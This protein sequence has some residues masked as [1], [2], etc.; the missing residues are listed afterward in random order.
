MQFIDI[1]GLNALGFYKDKLYYKKGE[2]IILSNL[3]KD[4]S[5]SIELPDQVSDKILFAGDLLYHFTEKELEIYTYL[6]D[7]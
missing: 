3:Y 1:K 4:G 7:D 6:S 2:S 5:K